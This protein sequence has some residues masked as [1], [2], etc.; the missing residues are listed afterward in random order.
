MPYAIG[1]L[2]T[3]PITYLFVLRPSSFVRSPRHHP[4]FQ[5]P[6]PV[7]AT[8]SMPPA[9]AQRPN[10]YPDLYLTSIPQYIDKPEF[11]R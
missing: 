4:I 9:F 5:P 7:C 3:R 2:T 11:L 8:F 1:G 6:V 10:L